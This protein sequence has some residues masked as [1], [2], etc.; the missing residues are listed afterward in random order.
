MYEEEKKNVSHLTETELETVWLVCQGLD[1]NEIA[2]V[3]IIAEATVRRDMQFVYRRLQLS[4]YTKAMRIKMIFLIYYPLLEDERIKRKNP[5]YLP[6]I[7]GSP[8]PKT[9]VE[10]EIEVEKMV[11][12]DIKDI[13]LYGRD[14]LKSKKS[15]TNISHQPDSDTVIK[16]VTQPMLPPGKTT[17]DGP[18]WK[19]LVPLAVVLGLL[20][21]VAVFG[22]GYYFNQK[23]SQ[24][25]LEQTKVA[26]QQTQ[27]A[28]AQAIQPTLM[29]VQPTTAP[30][31]TLQVIV[32]T[33]TPQPMPTVPPATAVPIPTS[34]PAIQLP[35]SDNFDK[36]PSPLWKVLS[37]N[38]ITAD[39]RYTITNTEG[40]WSLTAL[41]EPSW[42]NYRIQVNVNNPPWN[43]NELG[44][45]VRV[46]G[47]AK[48]LGFAVSNHSRTSWA[49]L[50][51]NDNWAKPITG[52]GNMDAPTKFDLDME[53]SGNQFIA[54]ING[55][56]SQRIS[57]SGYDNGG[58]MLGILC[59]VTACP[60]FDNLKID[61]LP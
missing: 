2:K 28:A 34:A 1:Y 10:E 21:C 17:T 48:Y 14:W 49:M 39:G 56:E 11:V 4:T 40:H 31:S 54:R 51:L 16:I 8:E 19:T 57:I 7:D 43:T 20:A 13:I 32:I 22:I 25:G 5:S 36:G 29:V 42:K 24:L 9:K 37:G 58:I 26:V 35:F 45:L 61:P 23:Q 46:S 47:G 53:V 50:T 41:D 6:I 33:A 12:D 27:V 15:S 30:S 52:F 59:N 38:W 3:R 55:A 44:V 60:S 18:M